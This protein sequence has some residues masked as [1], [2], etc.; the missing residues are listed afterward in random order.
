MQHVQFIK[1]STFPMTA[2]TKTKSDFRCQSSPE[3]AS[4]KTYTD[5]AAAAVVACLS[6]LLDDFKIPLQ[7]FFASGES[8]WRDI[9]RT[10]DSALIL[11]NFYA[12][13]FT[14]MSKEFP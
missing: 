10:L 3:L 2:E 11:T 9:L 12:L 14:A 4:G 1:F 8:V 5:E 13:G 6:K 7:G